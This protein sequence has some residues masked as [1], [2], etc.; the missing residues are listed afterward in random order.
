MPDNEDAGALETLFLEGLDE[1]PLPAAR[2]T[3]LVLRA[4]TAGGPAVADPLAE[5]LRAAL[6]EQR[7]FDELVALLRV[8]AAW[9][10]AD[11]AFR[12]LARESLERAASTR[13]R[14]ALARSAGWDAAGTGAGECLRRLDV[15]MKLVP[16]ALCHDG[17]WGFGSCARWTICTPASW[18]TS[19][20]RPGT[21]CRSATRAKRW[22]CWT[23]TISSRGCTATARR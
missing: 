5:M 4:R 10:D 6:V 2:L 7:L 14:A 17:T 15:L 22:S 19:G 13:L 20:A 1:Q 12:L 3:E 21:P 11:P 23:R 8:W 9:R 18:S 16:G